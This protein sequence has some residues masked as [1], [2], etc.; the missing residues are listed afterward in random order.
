MTNL[1]TLLLAMLGN[2]GGGGEGGTTNYNELDN[3]PQV[4]G[5]TLTGNKNSKDLN[6]V[7]INMIGASDGAAALDGEGKVPKSQLPPYPNYDTEIQNINQALDDKVDETELSSFKEEMYKQTGG[8]N[9]FNLAG[10]T[11]RLSGTT[12]E[13]TND[14]INIKSNA[15]AWTSLSLPVENL[16]IGKKYTLK[17][18]ISNLNKVGGAIQVRIRETTS[19]SSTTLL[20]IVIDSEKEY[21]GDFTATNETSGLFF[22][23][24]F[25]DGTY[26]NSFTCSEIMICD[27]ELENKDYVPY[28]STNMELQTNILS[29]VVASS[30]ASA[31]NSKTLEFQGTGKSLEKLVIEGK[32]VQDGT[33][34]PSA[35]V[36]VKGVGDKIT[37]MIGAI[38]G[39]TGQNGTNRNPR[40]RID[41]YLILNE[42]SYEIQTNSKFEIIVYTYK[43]DGTFISATPSNTWG[44]SKVSITL[45]SSTKIRCMFRMPDDSAINPSECVITIINKNTG[46]SSV[47]AYKIPISCAGKST[48]I[49]LN[50]PLFNGEKAD[51]VNGVAEKKY[52]IKV[53]DGSESWEYR[54][55]SGTNYNYF[56]LNDI[57]VSNVKKNVPVT[58]NIV[59]GTSVEPAAENAYISSGGA[60]AIFTQNA[61]DTAD[62]FKEFLRSMNSSGNPV[63]MIYPLATTTKETFDAPEISTAV[64]KN[65][66]TLGTEVA[67]TSISATSFGE[68]YSKA[69][70]DKML[71]LR[72]AISVDASEAIT[73]KLG[74]SSYLFDAA[75]ITFA[76]ATYSNHQVS[77][78]FRLKGTVKSSMKTSNYA[79]I[80]VLGAIDS[81]IPKPKT[82]VW[83]V[84]AQFSKSNNFISSIN[85]DGVVMVQTPGGTIADISDD[86]D[87]VITLS[88]M[89]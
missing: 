3:R 10:A 60:L 23:P 59:K 65:T 42:G 50:A 8:K 17:F 70:V 33:P 52:G 19:S 18:K 14:E 28:V 82:Q 72:D 85:T 30:N 57:G 41:D 49:Y 89:V 44:S 62:A 66:L 40:V 38:D 76:N 13:K 5:V 51:V 81:N 1:E 67:P 4:N 11:P 64:G 54:K 63:Y 26:T 74:G 53:F 21:S 48:N 58:T 15:L 73:S 22:L 69:E 78:S 68:Y 39:A 36:E 47:A 27:S 24:N 2:K 80:T 87:L 75:T 55:T 71:A 56:I 61:G 31:S 25:S 88:Y 34:S 35:P 6:L 32:T 86:T 84:A 77:I 20:A 9:I 37:Y 46:T 7:D 16:V 79:F 45:S 43:T 83:G 12:C 29:T